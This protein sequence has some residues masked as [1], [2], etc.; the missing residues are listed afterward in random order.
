LKTVVF[1]DGLQC[2]IDNQDYHFIEQ[3]A[4][5]IGKSSGRNNTY[6]VK[7]TSSDGVT[8]YLHRLILGITDKALKVDH[9]DGNGLNNTRTNLRL[10]SQSENNCNV[11]K[12]LK[13]NGQSCYSQYKGVCRN[14][15]KNKWVA[16]IS[17][18]NIRKHLGYFE[19]ECEAA[20]AY[21][22]AASSTHG[23]F[24]RLNNL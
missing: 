17:F 7:S 15:R 4:W 5:Y 10:S 19:D 1:K 23:K 11:A 3:Y 6:Y 20:K 16:Y 24:A 18:N 8:I 9:I 12:R 21:N 22:I 2:S 14:K 13:M